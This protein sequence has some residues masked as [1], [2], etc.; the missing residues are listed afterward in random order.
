MQVFVRHDSPSGEE[1][2]GGRRQ[3]KK[4][5][6]QEQSGRISVSFLFVP[7]SL[8]EKYKIYFLTVTGT[9][10]RWEN[11]QKRIENI[12]KRGEWGGKGRLTSLDTN[13]QPDT[14]GEGGRGRKKR[15]RRR[16]SR[17]FSS[18]SI[19]F[20]QTWILLLLIIIVKGRWT[21]FLDLENK[22]LHI[23]HEDDDGSK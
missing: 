9:G 21:Y 17:L 11:M 6:I 18:V 4:K 15:M 12:R 22:I 5:T 16:R 14:G 1:G 2:G 10:G 23:F 3:K 7:S 8:F 20:P 13:S 19:F